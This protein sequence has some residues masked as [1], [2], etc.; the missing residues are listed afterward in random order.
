MRSGEP[1]EERRDSA[2][3]NR[4]V[5]TQIVPGAAGKRDRKRKAR[6]RAGV[7]VELKQPSLATA[8]PGATESAK[9]SA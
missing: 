8:Q 2:E 4:V 3:K 6:E 9:A 7:I 5:D 1:E